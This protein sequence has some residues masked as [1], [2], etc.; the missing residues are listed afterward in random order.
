MCAPCGNKI[1]ITGKNDIKYYG[2]NK[3]YETLIQE[4]VN[5]KFI[6]SDLKFPLSICNSCRNTLVEYEK[7]CFLRQLPT[8]PNYTDVYLLR[9]TRSENKTDCNCYICLTA[10]YKGHKKVQKGRGHSR[11]IENKIDQS[12]GQWSFN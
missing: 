3:K 1:K 11:K 2:I 10:R 12:N 5:E 4:F 9:E 7:K 6:T 8:M